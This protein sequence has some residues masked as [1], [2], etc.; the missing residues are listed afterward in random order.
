MLHVLPGY[1]KRW[2]DIVLF[3]LLVTLLQVKV[4]FVLSLPVHVTR[5]VIWCC[6]IP[7]DFFNLI[8]L[9]NFHNLT[10]WIN[11]FPL[12]NQ[13]CNLLDALLVVIGA[14]L[15]YGNV[16]ARLEIRVHAG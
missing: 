13:H 2:I 16:D 5:C 4:L 1:S 12:I 10:R 3:N 6:L 14:F 8:A 15:V 11:I 7:I 9:L